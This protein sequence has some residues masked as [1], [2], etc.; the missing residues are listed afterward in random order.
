M[1]YGCYGYIDP[2]GVL[3][4]TFYVSDGWGYRVVRPGEEIE[5]FLHEHEHHGSDSG[6]HDHDSNNSDGDDHH[7]NH[8]GIITPWR[9]LKFPKD[10]RQFENPGP[11]PTRPSRPGY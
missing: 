6:N 2:F 1:T 7:N 11:R 8:H 4:A 5:L 3:Q 10:C 9:D